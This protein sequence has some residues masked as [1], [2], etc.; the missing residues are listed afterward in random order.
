MFSLDQDIA[1]DEKLAEMKSKFLENAN[2]ASSKETQHEMFYTIIGTF[3]LMT[4][5]QLAIESEVDWEVPLKYDVILKDQKESYINFFSSLD[6]IQDIELR[7]WIETALKYWE[8]L[9]YPELHKQRLSLE[10]QYI[11]MLIMQDDEKLKIKSVGMLKRLIDSLFN[12]N[13]E[14]VEQKL[15]TLYQLYIPIIDSLNKSEEYMKH[16]QRYLTLAIKNNEG[17]HV[18]LPVFHRLLPLLESY[19][20]IVQALNVKS[21]LVSYLS[22]MEIDNSEEYDMNSWEYDLHSMR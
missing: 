1:S 9:K 11:Q 17:K 12:V 8:E 3:G 20:Y 18:I 10:S 13:I 21:Q 7:P 16:A 2:K 14:Y 6:N 22:I 19:G 15:V 5:I 4:Q